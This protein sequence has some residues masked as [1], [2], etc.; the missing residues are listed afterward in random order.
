MELNRVNYNKRVK[1][2]N[3]SRKPRKQP[4]FMCFILFI[5]CKIM[6]GRRYKVEKINMKGQKAPYV[7]LSNH[8]AFVDFKVNI[9]ATFPQRVNNIA[10]LEQHY[11]RAGIMRFIGC[12]PK[13]KFTTDP[14]LLDACTTVLNDYKSVLSIYPEARFSEIGIT[15]TIP[16]S[17]ASLIKKLGKSVVVLLHHGNH[18]S[19]PFWNWRKKRK[20]KLYATMTKI[21]DEKDV[22][23]K[24]VDEIY[25]ILLKSLEYDD[26][27]YQKEN[28]IEIKEKFRAE[29]LH[30]VLYKCPHCNTE[31]KISS[32]GTTL[33]CEN[34]GKEWEMTTL[35]ELVAKD[36]NTEFSHIP[37]WFKW[38]KECVNDE[39]D[40]GLYN[41]ETECDVYSLPNP[42]KFIYL[43]KAELKHSYENGF[44]LAGEYNKEKYIISRP[45]AGMSGIH[46]EYDYNYIHGGECLQL[47]TRDDTFVCYPKDENVVTKI[48]FATD[49]MYKKKTM[50]REERKK[51]KALAIN[52]VSVNKEQ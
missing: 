12:I 44:T 47:S 15:G 19:A 33:K 22:Q 48:F 37:D 43:G 13:R 10:T 38:E 3:T 2:Y 32:K 26:Y 50:D 25:D 14:T 27:K 30:K 8:M 18:L 51:R 4:W 52:N 17:Y 39:I 46:I 49:I 24:S 5:L 9:V 6:L 1:H 45:T 42:N 23:E 28:N 35:G 34:C 29:G 40:R 16:K 36:G 31:Y 20:V 41:F 7:L 21:L 11:K